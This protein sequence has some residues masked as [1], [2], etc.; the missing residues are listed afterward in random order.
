MVG[1]GMRPCLKRK[2]VLARKFVCSTW[3]YSGCELFP[4]HDRRIIVVVIIAR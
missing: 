3:S 2:A 4:G 1:S